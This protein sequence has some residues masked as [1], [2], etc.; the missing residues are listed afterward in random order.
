MITIITHTIVVIVIFDVQKKW[1]KL[2]KFGGEGGGGE[3]IQ[4][5]P[6]RIFFT[7]GLPLAR[8][9]FVGTIAKRFSTC[10]SYWDSSGEIS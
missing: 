5:M 3:V 6:E 9:S 10:D 7:G 4:A 1:Y 2:P 8:T